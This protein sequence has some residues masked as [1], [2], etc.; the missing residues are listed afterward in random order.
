[1]EKTATT[2]ATTRSLPEG[3]SFALKSAMFL[4][5]CG[6][7]LYVALASEYPAV[8]DAL[9]NVRHALAIVPCH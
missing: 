4:V 3:I 5:A 8:H 2:Y 1:M 9:H 6:A 7:I